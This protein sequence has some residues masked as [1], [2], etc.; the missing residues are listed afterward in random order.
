MK[1]QRGKKKI[2]E[3]KATI[4]ATFNNT[5]ISITS[6]S[7]DVLGQ[8][9]AGHCGFK[10]SRK[11]TP[12][13]AQTAAETAAKGAMEKYDLKRVAV[14]VCGPGSGRDSAIRALHSVGLEVISLTDT[15][16]T[17][18]NGCRPRKKRRV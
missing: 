16:P 3:G 14:Q 13:A 8:S 10:G 18:H 1:K 7:G 2:S 12:F 5:V 9:S 17:P 11:G 15:T 4:L 6:P